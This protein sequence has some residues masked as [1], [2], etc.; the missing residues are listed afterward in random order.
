MKGL[1]SWF[2]ESKNITHLTLVNIADF[3]KKIVYKCNFMY[4]DK[5][6]IYCVKKIPDL[7]FLD[8]TLKGEQN[9]T[10]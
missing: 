8:G 6:I 7:T 9:N 2:C 3:I 4:L 10:K 1:G 5:F